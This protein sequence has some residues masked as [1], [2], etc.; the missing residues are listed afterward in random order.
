MDSRA[1]PFVV[2]RTDANSSVCQGP[3]YSPNVIGW[4]GSAILGL[5]RYISSAEARRPYSEFQ[6]VGVGRI[7]HTTD[8]ELIGFER[9]FNDFVPDHGV[10]FNQLKREHRIVVCG[11][12]RQIECET[13][14]FGDCRRAGGV[15]LG[16]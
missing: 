1:D 11:H 5:P 15:R 13:A 7:G 10:I 6:Y 8:A 16:G 14:G 9:C 2:I 12:Q 4:N 3:V